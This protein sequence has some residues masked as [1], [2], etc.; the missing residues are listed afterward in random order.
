MKYYMPHRRRTF[1]LLFLTFLLLA[2]LVLTAQATPGYVPDIQ[3]PRALL[4]DLESG[5]VL[6]SKNG[7]EV[8]YPASTTKILTAL[9]V[10]EKA[11]LQDVIAIDTPPGVRGSSMHIVPGEAFTVETLLRALMIRSANDAAEIL[12]KH[13]SGSVENFALLMNQRAA[14]LGALNTHFT[15]PH[16]LPD[17]NHVTTAHDLALI[18]REAMKHDFFREIVASTSL[19][20]PPTSETDQRVYNNSN[21]FLWGKGP[22]HQ[23]MYQGAYT[24]IY[25]EPVDGIKTGFTNSARN[26]LVSSANFNGA[27][28][29]AVVLNTEQENI[30]ADSRTLLDYGFQHFH[31]LS[32]VEINKT[33]TTLPVIQGDVEEMDLLT[34]DALRIML[35]R[36]VLSGDVRQEIF[37]RDNELMAPVESGYILGHARYY[38]GDEFLGEVALVARDSVHFLP[39]YQRISWGV[40]GPLSFLVLFFIWQ[41]L[42]FYL[43]RRKNKRRRLQRAQRYRH[44][45]SI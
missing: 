42:V 33:L 26:C 1:M 4:M 11:S 25:Y 14:A 15:N 22:N 10:L 32:L 7:D 23:M 21:R 29:I 28:F 36:N 6:Y 16:G 8:T 34:T 5:R 43:R 9:I 17:E 18:A 31:K 37:V 45:E 35:P 13:V 38:F 2:N 41:V 40:Y 30:Y 44:Y 12:A 20:I 24:N 27:R 19:V 39:T 3:A